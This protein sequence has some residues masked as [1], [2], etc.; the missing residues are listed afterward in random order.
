MNIFIT[1]IGQ[2]VTVAAH[3][4]PVK[5][6]A[7][8]REL[9]VI[10]NGAVL[11]R[12]GIVTET[13]RAADL[14]PPGD[15]DVLNAEGRVALPGFVDSHTHAVF[16]GSREDEFAMRSEGRSYQEI[17]AAG[18]GIL[19]TVR[20]TREATKRS[21]IKSAERRLNEMMRQGT[22]T[23]EVKSG[24]GLSPDGEM[25]I[26]EV[27]QELRE[28]SLATVVPTFLGAHAVPP[29]FPDN[30]E[31][32]VDL[33]VN[34]M[35]PYAAQRHLAVFCDVF[36]DEGYFSV[37]QAERILSEAKEHG[38]LPK[39]H[40]DELAAIGG[41]EL[42]AR[43]GAVSVDHLERC[44]PE[45]IAALQHAGTVAT[46]L[47]GVSFFLRHPYAPARRIIDAGIPVAIAT[48]CNPGTSMT[49]SM[50]LMMTIACT[51][52]GMLPEESIT[53]AT[54]NGAAALGLSGELG[55]IEPG[56]QADIVLFDV[57]TYRTIPYHFGVN[58]VWRVVKNGV[59]LEF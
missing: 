59:L 58:H 50:P 11:V 51:Q 24:Y 35:L 10:E 33:V 13:G 16:A 32:Y 9:G 46:L 34:R 53:A 49:F 19:S 12:N 40:A 39:V 8:M 56:K 22:T 1:N 45:G 21:L 14:R 57:P 15:V 26:L 36:C 55:S 3:G 28:S 5:R 31:A 52:M 6:G 17:A 42:A 38:L 7:G 2:L 18:G 43:I 20:A 47:P 23:V 41:T 54:L 27:I 37:R 44:T 25:K 29:E 48:D 30:A 4:E